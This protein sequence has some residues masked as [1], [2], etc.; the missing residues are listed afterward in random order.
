MALHLTLGGYRL[1]CDRCGAL[2][3]G[4]IV[5]ITDRA[6]AHLERKFTA[7]PKCMATRRARDAKQ[8]K[9]G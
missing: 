9:K 2:I 8:R 5:L 1:T 4:G 3:R 7:C 6:V